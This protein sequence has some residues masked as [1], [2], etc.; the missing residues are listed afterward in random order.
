MNFIRAAHKIHATRNRRRC[1]S[2]KQLRAPGLVA[3]LSRNA[4]VVAVKVELTARVRRLQRVKVHG[5]V[6]NAHFEAVVPIDLRKVIG[7]LQRLADFIGWQEVIAAK[8]LQPLDDNRR[9][10]TV[11]RAL[12]DTLNSELSWNA[13]RAALWAESRGVEVVEPYVRH[14]DCARRENM[15]ISCDSLVRFCALQTL[16]ESAAVGDASKNS[17][18]KLRVIY[19]AEADE[20]LVFL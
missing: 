17:R 13:L 1:W 12:W 2:Q 4:G 8:F 5:L 16:L 18:N 6:F 10:S 20:Y 9:Q 11:L 14:V 3:A 15:G 7:D 19:V